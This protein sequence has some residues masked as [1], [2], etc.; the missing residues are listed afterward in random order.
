VSYLATGTLLQERYEILCEIGRGGYSVVYAA[1]DRQLQQPVAIKQLIPPPVL[2]S[3]VRER[4]RREVLAARS[5]KHPHIVPIYDWVEAE[6]WNF[7]VME[8]VDGPNL[9]QLLSERGPFVPDRAAAIGQSIAAALAIAHRRGILHRDVKPQNILLDREGNAFLADFG[10]ARIDGQA[11]L[12][13]TG[14][15]VGTLGYTAPEAIAGRRPDARADLYS[16]GLTLYCILTGQLPQTAANQ[17]LPTDAADGYHPRLIRSDVPRWLDEIVARATCAEPGDRF[18]TAAAFQDA[19][20]QRQIPEVTIRPSSQIEAHCLVCGIPDPLN[21]VVCPSCRGCAPADADTFIRIVPTREPKAR[22]ALA[23][24]LQLLPVSQSLDEVCRGIQP[25][26]LVPASS[27]RRAIESLAQSEIVARETPKFQIWQAIPASFYG[28]VVAV[29]GVGAASVPVVGW[30]LSP[31]MASSLLALAYRTVQQPLLAPTPS[32]SQLS[33]SL[34]QLVVTTIDRL[35]PGTARQLLSDAIALGQ[36]AFDR[37]SAAS[38]QPELATDLADLL[39]S[40]CRAAL[41]L[42]R[43]DSTLTRLEACPSTLRTAPEW[44]EGLS[45]CEQARGCLIQRFLEAIAAIVSCQSQLA[46][47]VFGAERQLAELTA[48]LR[49]EIAIQAEA[50]REVAAL[51]PSVSTDEMAIA[52]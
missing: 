50:A 47:S 28:L 30:W 20:I 2:A 13:Q 41:E 7:I 3:S 43:L 25:L 17:L 38:A 33:E 48:E 6:P 35:S 5:L 23:Q 27:A 44:L 37:F 49:Q 19:L 26:A 1:T 18:A 24:R 42:D 36:T 14:A 32:R 39:A 8:L 46:S 45:Q 51:I 29:E 22:Q 12:T 15:F 21:L 34:Q 16:L 10:S 9:Q 31:L 11:T 4:C 52:P 40:A